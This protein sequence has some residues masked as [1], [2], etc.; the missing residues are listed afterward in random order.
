M[1][2]LPVDGMNV[3][4]NYNINPIKTL[5]MANFKGSVDLLK[6]NGAQVVTIEVNG[7]PQ[8]VVAIPT[9]WNDIAVTSDTEGKP[10][11][12]YLNLRAWETNE[13]FRKA[14]LERD[15]EQ[16]P[17]THQIQV[18][19]REEFQN[20]AQLAAEKRLRADDSYMAK[21]PSEE[22]I[23]KEAKYAVSNKS[24]IGTLTAM[25]KKEAP[26]Y[27]GQAPVA[28]TGAWAPPAVDENGNVNPGDDLP[29]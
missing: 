5:K 7:K 21:N 11:G 19:Y 23:L 28:A 22:D 3:R 29:F 14:C 6:L 8:T 27:T 18:S 24:R 15:P 12:A 10:K 2:K 9:G 17:P 1:M 16:E 25:V 13:K 26:A 20:A 4:I